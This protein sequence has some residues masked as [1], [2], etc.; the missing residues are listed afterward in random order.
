MGAGLIAGVH[1][2]AYAATPGT[3]IVAVAD[4]VAAKAERLASTAD[5]TAVPD[6]AGLLD[7]DL[8]A[9]SIC[10]PP[11]TH[12]DL[13][14]RSLQAGLDVLCEK[15]VARTL[16]DARRMEAAAAA[17]PGLLMVGH[18][19][20]FEPDHRQARTVIGAG[21]LGQV[22]MM[23]HSMT[24]SM[25]GWSE[26]GWLAD[27]ASSGGPLLDLGVHSF[28]YLAWLAGSPAIRVH[29]VG[30]DTALGPATYALAT[31]RYANGALGLVEASWAHPA[32]RGF[33]LAA[34][35]TGSDGRLSW[36]YDRIRGG[37]LHAAAGGTEYLEP[38]GERGFAAEIGA[39]VAAVRAGAPSPVPAGEGLA[40]L[41]TAL[42]AAESLRTGTVV[43]LRSWDAA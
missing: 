29:A 4:P 18:V 17:A 28:D 30:R 31:V 42:A 13:T 16:A 11:P 43:D 6:L 12:A 39:F 3:R 5:A 14:V 38:L 10:T 19:S 34:E 27:P 36:D 33:R 37:T 9:V 32:H 21:Q 8:D 7:L 26:G 2:R 41:R 20:R 23:S 25:P 35:L 15:P 22:R 40:A 24:T 1:A